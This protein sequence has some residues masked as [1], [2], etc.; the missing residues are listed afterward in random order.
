M[1]VC[2][3]MRQQYPCLED[4]NPI[5]DW[6]NILVDVSPSHD[7]RTLVMC[8]HMTVEYEYVN[9]LLTV[10]SALQDKTAKL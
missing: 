8:S 1:W 3:V 7:V 2:V 10:R 5:A 6:S 4:T 9:P